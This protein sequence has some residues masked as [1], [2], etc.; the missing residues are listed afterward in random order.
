MPAPPSG[1][2]SVNGSL[3]AMALAAPS[4]PASH[5]ARQGRKRAAW[6]GRTAD[7]RFLLI[8]MRAY[9]N[10]VPAIRR[11]CKAKAAA[12]LQQLEEDDGEA[13]DRNHP[14]RGAQ[15]RNSRDIDHGIGEARPEEDLRAEQR[16]TV[17]ASCNDCD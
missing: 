9:L 1:S 14:R 2:V 13:D 4:A 8:F 16:C 17:G 5:K 3:C 15:P 7:I 12:P 6:T 11:C 10:C